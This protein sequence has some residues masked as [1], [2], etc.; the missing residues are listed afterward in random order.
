MIR[1]FL[2]IFHNRMQYTVEQSNSAEEVAVIG[3][4]D[5]ICA[6]F[7]M[8]LYVNQPSPVE[9]DCGFAVCVSAAAR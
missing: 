1:F 8:R 6:R 3:G 2:L 5:H 9:N 7:V 4:K